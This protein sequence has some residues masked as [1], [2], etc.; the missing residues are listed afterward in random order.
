MSAG[1]KTGDLKLH[2][3]FEGHLTG[4]HPYQFSGQCLKFVPCSFE[5]N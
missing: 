3:F 2:Q 1:V 5:I 4:F